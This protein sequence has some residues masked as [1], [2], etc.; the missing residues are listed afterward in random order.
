MKL[1]QDMFRLVYLRTVQSI[2]FRLKIS[3]GIAHG[4]VQPQTVK[5]IA[6]IIMRLYLGLLILF[7]AGGVD[8]LLESR[9]VR[10][11]FPHLAHK[12]IQYL[13]EV[14]VHIDIASHISFAQR[15]RSAGHQSFLVQFP[16]HFYRK[17]RCTVSDFVNITVGFDLKWYGDNI[18]QIVF[19]KCIH[20][21]PLFP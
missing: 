15:Q 10:R 6:D 17:F 9:L 11:K 16:S 12:E 19:Y 8:D 14:P 13:K 7:A 20:F 18:L 5:V 1:F 4:L 2:V 21:Y 3:A